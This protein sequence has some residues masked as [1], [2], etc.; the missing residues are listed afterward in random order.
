MAD[1][2]CLR[3]KRIPLIWDTIPEIDASPQL[4]PDA[5]SYFQ[6]I[7][8]ILRWMVELVKIDII[9]SFHS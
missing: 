8:V 4:R 9:T 2:D 6:S 1:V 5:A 7:V 3:E